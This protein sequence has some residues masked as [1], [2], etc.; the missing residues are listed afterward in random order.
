MRK[1]VLSVLVLLGVISIIIINNDNEKNIIVKD[2]IDIRNNNLAMYKSED[3]TNYTEITEMP[4]EGYIINEERTYC[5]MDN[6]TQIKGKVKSIEGNTIVTNIK[7]NDKC[8]LY[9]DKQ[10]TGSETILGNITVNSGT[11]N[12]ANIATTDEGVYKVEDGMYGGYSYYWRGA[13]TNNYVKFA[14]KCWRIIRINGDGSMR[15][16]YDGT[17]CHANGT[18]TTES[19][20]VTN[21]K[22]NASYDRSEYVGYTYTT[23]SQRTTSGTAS[24]L[25]TQNETWYNSNLASYAS[26]IAD[27]KYCNDRNTGAGYSWSSQPSST[28]YYAGYDRSGAKSASSVSPTLSCPSGDVYTL[29]VGAIT[30]DEV[31]MAGGKWGTANSSYYLYNGNYYWTMSPYSTSSNPYASVFIVYSDGNLASANANGVRPVINL[32]ADTTFSDGNGTLDNPYVVS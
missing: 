32:K 23:G 28:F 17:T 18:S 26:K 7:K 9:F 11:P 12:F 30:M 27:G 13:V 10:P 2:N 20:A 24:N 15:L 3:G 14:N 31:V 5:T 16:I 19:L 4:S 25:K 8:Y 21:Q 22:Y 6:K 1:K 29:K